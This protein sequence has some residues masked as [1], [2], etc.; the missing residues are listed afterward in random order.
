[1]YASA[2]VRRIGLAFSSC[3]VSVSMVLVWLHDLV[4][5]RVAGPVSPFKGRD[6]VW[7]VDWQHEVR[8]V[9]LAEP[10]HPL[11]SCCCE[12][13]DVVD[14]CCSRDLASDL[15]NRVLLGSERHWRQVPAPLMQGFVDE[16]G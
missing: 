11:C 14:C 7:G 16:E 5:V 1:V 15:Q 3:R 8:V 6:W 10:Q 13:F 9:V 4:L 12:E 2:Q